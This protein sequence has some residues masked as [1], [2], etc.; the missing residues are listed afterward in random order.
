MDFNLSGEQQMLTD[1]LGRFLAERYDLTVRDGIA[2]S[3]TGWSPQLWRQMAELGIIGAILSENAGGFAG[4]AFDIGAVFERLG[5]A[6]VV[7]PFLSVLMAGRAI[8]GAGGAFDRLP[9]IGAGEIIPAFAHQEAGKFFHTESVQTQASRNGDG[10]RLSGKKIVVPQLAAADIIVVSARSSAPQAA[11]EISLFLVDPRS[12]GVELESYA[13]IDGGRG[14]DL[15]LANAPATLL[16]AEGQATPVIADAVAAGIV[17]LAWEAVGIMDV[18]KSMMLEFLRTRQQFDRPIGKFQAVQHRMATIAMEIEQAR[19]SA[20]NAAAALDGPH[21]P[22]DRAG[23]AAKYTIGRVGTIVAEEVIQLHGGI[24]MTWEL[25]LSHYAKRLVMIGHQLGDEDDH[26][27]RFVA[28]A[29][30]SA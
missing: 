4:D 1:M 8:A 10:W 22:R 2:F 30:Q 24:G 12:S 11:E 14:G 17:A 13:L 29:R 27:D 20:I 19:S 26:L 6:L 7:E 9:L 5:G 28:L 16:G 18:L 21:I 3:E 25:P 15:L 23:S